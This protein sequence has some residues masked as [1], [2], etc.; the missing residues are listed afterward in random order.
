MV[1]DCE[2]LNDG[3]VAGQGGEWGGE[4]GR[5]RNGIG[6]VMKMMMGGKG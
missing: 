5:T 1:T 2:C 3:C 6:N 4:E